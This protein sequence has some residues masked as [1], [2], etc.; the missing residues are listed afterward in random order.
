MSGQH[1]PVLLHETL[2]FLL[3][4]PGWYLD[5]TLGSGG[6]A[7]ALLEAEPGARLLACDRDTDALSRSALRL[8]RFGA[9]VMFAHAAFRD[10][11]RAHADVGATP[12]TGVLF[13]LGVSSPQLDDPTR[14]MSFRHDGPLDLRMDRSRGPAAAEWLSRSGAEEITRVLRDLGD[15]TDAGRIA[16][17]IVAAAAA[18]QMN[19]TAD[20][21][22]AVSRASGGRPH[23]RR[24]A[25]VFQALRIH[26][27][28]E[29]GELDSALAWLP[30]AVRTGGVVVTLAYHSGEDRRIKQMLRGAPR[31]MA[32]RRWP[33]AL[34][35]G[36]PE[37][38]WHELT[39]KV[40]TP[41]AAE[42]ARNPRARSARLRAFRRKPS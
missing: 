32:H 17:A 31:P 1:E 41:S 10:L 35:T 3:G 5:A 2:R 11:S 36:A 4:G 21:V 26:L 8:A 13:D 34:D 7:E 23:P 15:V 37:S 24:L 14:G 38:P 27:N 39:R 40:V 29:T 18:G 22:S 25:Q 42:E 33:S 20:L 28:D 6:H 12:L 30:G 9:R 19:T 16:R